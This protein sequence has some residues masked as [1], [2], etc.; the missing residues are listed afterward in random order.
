MN[1]DIENL[2][3]NQDEIYFWSEEIKN[4]EKEKSEKIIVYENFKVVYYKNFNLD[5]SDE[6]LELKLTENEKKIFIEKYKQA[7]L[8]L[9]ENYIRERLFLFDKIS[10]FSISIYKEVEMIE[11]VNYG[12]LTFIPEQYD[13]NKI[14]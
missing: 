2:I 9:K 8:E 5:N 14:Y 1:E 12:Y 10:S 3:K 6:S 11:L 7:L 13:K 4:G